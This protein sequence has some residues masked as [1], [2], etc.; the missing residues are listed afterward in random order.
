[1]TAFYDELLRSAGSVPG[2]VAAAESSAPRGVAD[3]LREG[4]HTQIVTVR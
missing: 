2:V 4:G 1:M 3:M